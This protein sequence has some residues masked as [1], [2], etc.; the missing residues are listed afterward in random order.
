MQQEK[1][2]AQNLKEKIT[3][4][5]SSVSYEKCCGILSTATDGLTGWFSKIPYFG[6][7]KSDEGEQ[8]TPE[9]DD[10]V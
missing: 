7:K 9:S 2:T 4:I 6:K 8:T 3:N 5:S 10:L 1:T